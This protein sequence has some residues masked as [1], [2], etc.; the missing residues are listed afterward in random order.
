MSVTVCYFIQSHRDPEQVY[1][2]VRTLHRGSPTAVVVVQ[3]NPAGCELDLAPI[4]DLPRVHAFHATPPQLRSDFSCQMQPYFDAVD[5]LEQEGITYDWMINLSAQDYPVVPIGQM[6]TFL[7]HA[8]ADGFL[9]FWDVFSDASP[10]SARKARARYFHRY[11]LLAP[12]SERFLRALR[13]LTKILPIHFYLDYG[14]WF[15]VRRWRTPFQEGFRCFGGWAWFSLRRA[16]LHY[17]RDF[18]RS[19][20]DVLA[21]YRG[22]KVPEESLVQTVLANSG[23]FRLVDDD[24][25]YID[26]SAAHKGSPRVL[27]EKDLPLFASGRYHFARKFDLGV[28]AKVLDRIDR[29]LLGMA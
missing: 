29:E 6:E 9:R 16:A 1:R 22:T 19:H 24:F 13:G 20:P 23:K 18:L 7:E 15:G 26:Y 14:P 10:W 21:H 17:V 25:R 4:R 2:L 11:Q 12:G 8:E 5:W 27:T 28:D 3:H